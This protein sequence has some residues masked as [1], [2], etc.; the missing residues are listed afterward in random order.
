MKLIRKHRDF[1][2]QE[3]NWQL[4][5]RQHSV[6]HLG[7]YS[8]PMQRDVY[9]NPKDNGRFHRFFRW[10]RNQSGQMLNRSLLELLCFLLFAPRGVCFF[11]P[12]SLRL[13]VPWELCASLLLCAFFIR[14][15][16]WHL[17]VTRRSMTH[18]SR[19]YFNNNGGKTTVAAT[20]NLNGMW[21]EPFPTRIQEALTKMCLRLSSWCKT[22]WRAAC[23]VSFV[24][25]V[26]GN[27]IA[28]IVNGLGMVGGTS[29]NPFLM[30]GAIGHR[31]AFRTNRFHGTSRDF[32]SKCSQWLVK[33]QRCQQL[34]HIH[35]GEPF[36]Q[37]S[38]Q[39]QV[40]WQRKRRMRFFR[41]I[42]IFWGQ[43]HRSDTSGKCR[44]NSFTMFKLAG[45]F[46][47]T[48]ETTRFLYTTSQRW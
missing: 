28:P 47:A 29:P 46:Q 12:S 35:S 7:I 16:H 9:R 44:R 3:T 8:S 15:K 34:R 24:T 21:L 6:A 41:Q 23:K 45:S 22:S 5:L 26:E 43:L 20:T 48:S 4:L 42:S 32:F 25:F 31:P 38:F 14:R 11:R 30:L 33:F 17:L 39:H 10:D 40:T 1:C 27:T 37:I 18:R 13:G 19:I 2:A 36:C